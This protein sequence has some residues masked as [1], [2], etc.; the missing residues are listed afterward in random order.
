MAKLIYHAW[1]CKFRENKSICNHPSPAVSCAIA[2]D[3]PKDC[4]LHDGRLVAIPIKELTKQV[5]NEVSELGPSY[6]K[7]DGGQL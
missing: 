3:F 1:Q 4:P 6:L 7:G 2:F 5:E